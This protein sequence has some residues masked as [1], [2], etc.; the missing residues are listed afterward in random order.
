[1]WNY[2]KSVGAQKSRIKE[3]FKL[4]RQVSLHCIVT[5]PHIEKKNSQVF[6]IG[7]GGKRFVR[8]GGYDVIPQKSSNQK[9]K[10]VT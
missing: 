9:I 10:I 8:Y 7:Q 1:M 2:L 6:K 4:K 3:E 5:H